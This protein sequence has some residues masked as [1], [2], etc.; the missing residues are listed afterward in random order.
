[1]R[2]LIVYQ[3]TGRQWGNRIA[4]FIAE[5]APENWQVELQR[6][7]PLKLPV[8][9]E[10]EQF[11]PADLPDSDLL[12]ALV[13][14][15]GL[16]QIIPAIVAEIAAKAVIAPVDFEKGFPAGLKKQV[17]AELEE[18]GVPAITPEPF[19]SLSARGQNNKYLQEFAENYGRPEFVLHYQNQEDKI[20][21]VDVL[22]SSPCGGSPFVARELT[23][24]KIEEAARK[25]GLYHQYYPCKASVDLI[26]RSA[27]ITE[28][29]LKRAQQQKESTDDQNKS[30][31]DSDKIKEA[32]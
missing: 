22:R 15:T 2:L 10:P 7:P 25:S 9:D 1:M 31:N 13:E 8:I 19:C 6:M 16:A 4:K 3:R 26:H 29:A 11:V 20:A 30:E 21:K 32:R 14:S 17:I 24:D 18:Q 5:T 23:D 12:L 27:Y 28:A